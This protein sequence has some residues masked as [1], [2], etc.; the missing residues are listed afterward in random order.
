M[1]LTVGDNPPPLVF[2]IPTLIKGNLS[3]IPDSTMVTI[4]MESIQTQ[5]NVIHHPDV[6]ETFTYIIAFRPEE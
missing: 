4:T 5:F 6:F 1:R 3:A 2:S